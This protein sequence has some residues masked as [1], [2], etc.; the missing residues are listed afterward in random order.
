LHPQVRS[1]ASE[2]LAWIREFLS[3]FDTA[4]L[5]WL[6]IDFGREHR[7]RKGRVYYK[8]RGVYGRCWYPTKKQPTIRLSCQVP[9]PFPC[10]IVTRKRP[11]YRN[12]DGTWPEEATR[13]R[14][15][16]HH[17]VTSG[18]QWKRVYSETR[19]NTLD[20]AVVWIF[21]HE[22]FHWLRKTRQIPGRNNEVEADGFADAKLAEF[23]SA[24]RQQVGAA[25][26]RWNFPERQG[27][28]FGGL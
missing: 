21:A 28:L 22:A 25:R 4:L 9:G 8:F 14:A 23:R 20:E 16:I 12:E 1:G 27:E 6:R 19:V 17:D 2:A 10:A 3:Q 18:R 15:P 7:D 11:I 13:R 5:G 26:H 24:E